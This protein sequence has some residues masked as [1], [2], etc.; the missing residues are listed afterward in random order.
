MKGFVHLHVHTS[1]SLLDGAC[2]MDK[3]VKRAKELKM[4]AL[5]I[6]DHGV[7][8]GVI[9]FY[10]KCK[11]E[12]I[13]PII[14]CEVYVAPNSRFD[15][16]PNIDDKPY[17]LVLL[18]KNNAGY[19]NLIKLVSL[20]HLEGF[21]YR[22]RV[23]REVLAKY[24]EGL[25][26][27]SAC[28]AGEVNSFLM[29][30]EYEAAK[31]SAIWYQQTFG[32][33]NFYLEIQ[34]QGLEEQ[35]NLNRLIAQIAKET[36]IPLVASN[37]VHYINKEDSKLQ[38]VLMCIQM[39][40][41]LD[42]ESRLKFGSDEFYLKDYDEMNLSL[43]EYQTAL[44]NTLEIA[45]KCDVELVFGENHMPDFDIPEAY[46]LESYLK[47][48]CL[49]GLKER[50]DEISQ[51]LIDRLNFELQTI[52][53]MGYPGYF[54]IVWDFI[55]YAKK[56]GIYVGPG[57]GSASGSLVSYTLGI[58]DI[59]PIKYE[60]LFE[61]FLNP[62]RVSMPD[63]DIDFCYERRSEVI[64]YVVSKYGQEHV[65]QIIT[66]GTMA[67]KAAIRDVGRV[68]N[69]PLGFIDKV[70]KLIPNE[71]GISLEKAINISPELRQLIEDRKSV[72]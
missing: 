65:S 67:A 22:P 48:L 68:M 38:D 54:L 57:R 16:R 64:D 34:N 31:E 29:K 25:I 28:L 46:T 47:E 39:G 69:I 27:T 26:V 59:D 63:I 1:Y 37:D 32:D 45:E 14:G 17:H 71:I 33:G 53:N 36:G 30:E 2:R 24:S 5:A 23:D 12:G 72:V 19:Q 13:K 42:D 44:D 56:Q 60:L 62:E 15:K 41:T 21:Y 40:K 20:A 3:I 49:E 61:R 55:K 52:N 6:T 9:D 35:D 7:M 43:G 18:A 8:Y 4:P 51:E 70:A 50:Y 11:A 10:K 66:F 58:T